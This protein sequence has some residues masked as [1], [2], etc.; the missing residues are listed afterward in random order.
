MTEMLHVKNRRIIRRLAW[1][2]LAARRGRNLV[3][4][5]AIALTTLL[6][7]ALF[8]I[9]G[10]LMDT[11][12]QQT[13][14]QVGGN[15]PAGFKKL[16]REQ[17][18]ELKNDPLI[19]GYGT[20]LMLG[21]SDAPPL[22]KAYVEVSYMDAVQAKGSFCQPETGRL[23][24]E[25]TKE[26]ACD[27]NILSLLG[28]EPE[29][30]AQ[31]PLTVTLGA[32]TGQETTLTDTF[33]LSG[34]WECDPAGMACMV[35]LPRSYVEQA[36]DGYTSAA[37]EFDSSG[38]W[39]LNF[40]LR[41]TAH[42]EADAEAILNR[43]GYQCT[44]SNAD[45]YIGVGINWAYLS[46][47]LE[48][49]ADPLTTAALTFLLAVTLLT[50]YL[51]IYNI[52][53]ISVCSDIRFYGLLKTIGTTPRQLGRIVRWQAL[54][55]CA[56]GIPLGLAGGHLL[57]RALAPATTAMLSY[58]RIETSTK[59]WIFVG[60]SLFS[61]MTVL[62]SCHRPARMAAKVSPVEAV[63]YTEGTVFVRH[64]T[65]RS[66]QGGRPLGM[67]VANLGR[68]PGKTAL[69]VVSLSLAA[70]LFQITWGL[71]QGFDMDKYL[72]MWVVSDFVL[73]DAGYFNSRSDNSITLED[74]QA[75]RDSGLAQSVSPI[76]QNY[77]VRCFEPE[78][79]Y[80]DYISDF[81]GEEQA[82]QS[83][84]L[85]QKDANGNVAASAEVYGMDALAQSKLEL[86][87]GDLSALN[88]P[89]R[90]A[91]AAVCHTNDFGEL[92]DDFQFAKLGDTVTLRY[93]EEWEYFDSRTGEPVEDPDSI[94]AMDV[95]SRA[96]KWH[97]VEYTV[98]ALVS[99]PRAMS[100]RHY[101]G[102]QFVLGQQVLERDGSPDLLNC[103]IETDDSQEAAMQAFLED[104][105]EHSAPHLNFESKQGY[106]STFLQLRNTFLLLGG[107]LSAVV[108][109]VGVLN[110]LNAVLTSIL[111]RRR[112]F[113]VLQAVGMTNRQLNAMLMTE[114]LLYA[115]LAAA[116]SL[117][118]SLL[119]GAAMRTVV[120]DVLWFFTYRFSLL[121]LAVLTPV[122]LLLG[123]TLPAACCRTAQRQSIVDRLRQTE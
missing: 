80:L 18:D 53:Q 101:A 59:P 117:A 54:T 82:R 98:A 99:V 120:G 102:A 22:N 52:F 42:I 67:A 108:A 37:P 50:G 7:T 77:G 62:L 65:R 114:G 40:Y 55:L 123:L 41:N 75:V 47:S 106:V 23:P 112:E 44:D 70:A 113:A 28:I 72:Q 118:L 30:G 2:T 90:H 51:I 64:T 8:T 119:A 79:F 97:D 91:I 95:S 85:M 87:E 17:L 104:Y 93:V 109:L 39:F 61:L 48:S 33:T 89:S 103:L 60:S 35:L 9:A 24:A 34:W 14:R 38:A 76:T 4:V 15:F 45:N 19:T 25:G 100:F 107:V 63:R 13:F 43:H 96:A 88:D 32:G 31:V 5:A 115:L 69:V 20:R 111:S 74:V 6:F 86:I 11:F 68:T 84:S 26:L 78:D 10:S 121:P 49:G 110:F 29:I 94:P 1:K 105:T 122:F 92:T 56:A 46:S 81:V 3:A 21:V 71:A 16:S 116:V 73:S 27:T 57:G 58:D 36:L 66:K 83:L 12:Q